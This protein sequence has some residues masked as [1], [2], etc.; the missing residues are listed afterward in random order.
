[1]GQEC[2]LNDREK[3]LLTVLGKN[4]E[5]SL[6]G[7]LNNTKYKR[8]SSISKKVNYFREQDILLGPTHYVD[9]GK[10]CKNPLCK[11][12]CILELNQSFETV[13]EYLKLIEPLI[14]VYPVLS[15][16]K[17]LLTV[18]FLSSNHQEVKALLQLLKESNLITDYT[19]RVRQHKF[20]LENP[21]FFGDPV[22]SLD[23]LLNPCE[24]PD[25]SFGQYDT[26][27][28]ECDIATLSHLHGGFESIKL[29]EILKKE[30]K[31]YNRKWTYN[32]IKYSYEKML[33]NKL[34]WKI[35]YI[36]PY[37]LHQCADFFLFLKAEDREVTQTILYNFA[38]E[39]RI[40]REY[41]LLGDWGLM[42]C[43]CHPQFVLDL[44]LKLDSIDEVAEK[45]LY[46]V[47]SNP[48]GMRYIGGHA[49][50]AYYDVETQNLEYPYRLFKEKIR[51]KLESESG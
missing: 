23:M 41:S 33:K 28:T 7:L 11:L 16:R 29:I 4:P 6:K 49:E 2:Q 9:L 3:D 14:W 40:H 32:Q 20:I 51:E 44:M 48:P 24:F 18:G 39:E 34:I 25:I 12:F 36:H 5:M 38:R 47:R 15:S 42:G 1:M 43:I 10:L 19:A 17:E 35:Y 26:E 46:H 37:P 22:P 31:L 30:R 8:V 45:E 27:W 21:N 13:I 50:F